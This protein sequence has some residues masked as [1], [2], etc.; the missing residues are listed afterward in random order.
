MDIGN[1]SYGNFD[2][3]ISLPTIDF[4]LTFYKREYDGTDYTWYLTKPKFYEDHVISIEQE[5]LI[6]MTNILTKYLNHMK[7][8]EQ[9]DCCIQVEYSYRGNDKLMKFYTSQPKKV[10]EWMTL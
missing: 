8:E 2:V 5:T 9:V 4:T 3:Y 6:N 7:L 10:Y 1:I